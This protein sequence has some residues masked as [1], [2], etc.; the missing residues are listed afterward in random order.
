MKKIENLAELLNRY[1]C[2]PISFSGT[3]DALFERRLVL[4]HVIDPKE[5]RPREQFEAF[6]TSFKFENIEVQ[7]MNILSIDVGGTNVKVLATGQRESRKIPSGPTMTPELMVSEVKK[8]AKGWEYDAVSIGY[9]GAVSE[10]RIANEPHNLASGWVTFDFEEAFGVPV[11]LIND[12]A[13]QALGCYEGGLLL[14]IG[15][16][17]GLGSALVADGTVVPM[18][19]G[20]LS[21]KNGTIEDYVGRRGLERLGKKKW[22]RYV[23]YTVNRLTEALRPDEI[24]LGGGNS[25]KFKELPPR[26]RLENNA[27]AFTGGFRLWDPA[28]VHVPLIPAKPDKSSDEEH[29]AVG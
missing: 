15:F 16:G 7:I 4:D 13:M 17:T 29:A 21:F 26:C 18:E 22:R 11:R 20:H 27:Y 1:G 24:V 9:P 6:A 5:S 28:T 8:I 19:L 23:T 10:G 2:G 14:F 12:A 3:S 25:K